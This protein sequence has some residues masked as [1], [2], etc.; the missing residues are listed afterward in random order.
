MMRVLYL[1][2][3]HLILFL[4]T[5]LNHYTFSC[6]STDSSNKKKETGGVLKPENT[7]FL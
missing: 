1:Q 3:Q 4:F 7:V 5:S 2:G 6:I